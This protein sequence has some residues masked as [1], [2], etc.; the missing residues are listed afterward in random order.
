MRMKKGPQFKSQI[1]YYKIMLAR[2]V[3][4]G[5]IELTE[6]ELLTIQRRK[7]TKK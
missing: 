4:K 3:E 6:E 2:E 5:N 7:S 1:D